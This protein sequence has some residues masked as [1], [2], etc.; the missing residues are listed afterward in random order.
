MGIR[1]SVLMTAGTTLVLA[2]CAPVRV[3]TVVSPDAGLGRLRTFAVLPVPRLRPGRRL[4]ED[5]PMLINSISYRVLRN[6]L[7]NAFEDRGYVEAG[8][9]PDFNVAYYA[10]T[11]E[12]LDVTWW[13]YG[14]VWRPRWWAGWGRGRPVATVYTEGTVIVDVVDATSH[15][16]LWRG[17]GVAT[18]SRDPERYRQNLR[19]IVEAIVQEFPLAVRGVADR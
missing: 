3:E 11:R 2:S 4:P 15:E 16:L 10:S 18:V 19:E 6:E 1:K 5:H 14:Y 9:R 17:R 13:D 7:R 12:K 8:T